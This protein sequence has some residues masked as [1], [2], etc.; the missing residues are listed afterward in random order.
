MPVDH[1]L[2]GHGWT[3][4]KIIEL[5]ER[6]LAHRPSRTKLRTLLNLSLEPREAAEL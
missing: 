6:L 5:V 1:G 2:P 3:V 4:P